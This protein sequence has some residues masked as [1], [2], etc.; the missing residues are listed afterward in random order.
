MLA[1]PALRAM[2]AEKFDDGARLSF[3]LA[4]PFLPGRDRTGRPRKREFAATFALPA[5]RLLASF[6]RVRGTA[7]DPFGWTAARRPERALLRGYQA[8]VDPVLA[9]LP[10]NCLPPPHATMET[11]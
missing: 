5:F 1:D 7:L 3:N 4:P 10:E 11:I 8:L 2:I 9:N 6:K